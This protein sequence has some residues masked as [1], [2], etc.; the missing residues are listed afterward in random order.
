[1]CT[2]CLCCQ[3][4]ECSRYGV[5]KACNRLTPVTDPF[6][7]VTEVP[8]NRETL[9]AAGVVRGIVSQLYTS[10]DKFRFHAT[11]TLVNLLAVDTMVLRELLRDGFMDC[12]MWLMEC[13]KTSWDVKLNVTSLPQPVYRALW[14]VMDVVLRS[15]G[16]SHR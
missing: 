14:V 16:Q 4:R 15:D 7:R 11:A 13:D 12:L 5:Y 9:A 10:S 3:V 8:E 2:P 6:S 1:V